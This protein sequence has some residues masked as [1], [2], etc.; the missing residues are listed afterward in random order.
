[1]SVRTNSYAVSTRSFLKVL[2]QLSVG[3]LFQQLPFRLIE[4]TMPNALSLS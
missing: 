3:A 4:Q 1:M 2:N